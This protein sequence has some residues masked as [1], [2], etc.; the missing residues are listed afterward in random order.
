MSRL[1]VVIPFWSKEG[2]F[3]TM[4]ADCVR[5]LRGQF[6]ELI[7]V[8]NQP[9]EEGRALFSKWVNLGLRLASGDYTLVLNSDTLLDPASN[10]RDL[11]VPDT[12]TCPIVN[13][14]DYPFWGCAFCIPRTVYAAHG[15]LDEAFKGYFEDLD[16][17]VRMYQAGVPIR[18]VKNVHLAHVGG[19]S[20]KQGLAVSRMEQEN[21]AIFLRKHGRVWHVSELIADAPNCR[22][23]HAWVVDEIMPDGFV[24]HHCERGD[25]RATTP[26]R[27]A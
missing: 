13:G 18:S 5:S 22:Q 2:H 6:D 1:S 24:A 10:L 17:C 8:S 11:C 20:Y 21:E 19:H 7:V 9:D 26:W 27:M 25:H 12:I 3:D 23:G 4:L 16:Y 15:G 14:D